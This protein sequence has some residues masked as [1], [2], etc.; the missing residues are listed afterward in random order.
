MNLCPYGEY[1]S[2]EIVVDFKLNAYE[3]ISKAYE[4]H[5]Y[6]L[7]SDIK[8]SASVQRNPMKGLIFL[9]N[10]KTSIMG[11]PHSFSNL[12]QKDRFLDVERL[13]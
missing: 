4:K 8:S 10:L 7:Y 5:G 1:G 3:N 6:T 11:T 2:I 9:H 13:M 12:G